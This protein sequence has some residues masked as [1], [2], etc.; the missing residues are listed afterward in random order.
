MFLNILEHI[1]NK[2]HLLLNISVKRDIEGIT[3][4]QI[5]KWAIVQDHKTAGANQFFCLFGSREV[6][7]QEQDS[8]WRNTELQR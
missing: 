4:H 3:E 7:K 6:P 8:N 2:E 1:K 5:E